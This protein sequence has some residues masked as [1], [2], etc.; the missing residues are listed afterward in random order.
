VIRICRHSLE[1]LQLVAECIGGPGLA[2]VC[3]LLAQD[4]GGWSGAV[5]DRGSC[6]LWHL[7][8]PASFLAAP[9]PTAST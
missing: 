1:D 4:H 6:L 7:C 3:R 9:S 8:V 5:T 2:Q